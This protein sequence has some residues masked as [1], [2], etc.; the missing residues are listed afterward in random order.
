MGLLD[1]G[2]LTLMERVRLIV[3]KFFPGGRKVGGARSK[4]REVSSKRKV[5]LDN[6]PSDRSRRRF[7][8]HLVRPIRRATWISLSAG[9]YARSAPSSFKLFG[10]FPQ[11]VCS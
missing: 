6:K 11:F 3:R 5:G 7:A 10:Q 9:Y 1:K 2:V 8:G 4:V